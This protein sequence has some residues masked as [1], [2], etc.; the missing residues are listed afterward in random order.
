[1]KIVDLI[2]ELVNI[3]NEQGNVDIKI[4]VPHGENSYISYS[5]IDIVYI[6]TKS[7]IPNL[8]EL[9]CVSLRPERKPLKIDIK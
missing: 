6:N 1:M 2:L 4:S 3:A 5:N 8:E 7:Y 9:K